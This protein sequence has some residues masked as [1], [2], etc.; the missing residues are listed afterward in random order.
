MADPLLA[1]LLV[2]VLQRGSGSS[3]QSQLTAGIRDAI[4]SGKLKAGA[5]LP[6]SRT[7]AEALGVARVTVVNAYDKLLIDGYLHTGSSSGTFVV[8]CLLGAAQQPTRSMNSRSLSVRGAELV[9]SPAGIQERGGAFVPGVCDSE[10]FP[11]QTWK[12]I[13]NRYLGEPLK[14]LTGYVNYGGYLPLRR[15]LSEYLRVSRAVQATPEQIIVTMGSNQSIDLCARVLADQGEL[16]YIENPSYWAIP[17]ILRACGLAVEAVD[18]DADGMRVHELVKPARLVVVTPSHQ[19]PMGVTMS[20]QRRQQLLAYAEASDAYVLEDDY[21]SEFRYDR[22]PLPSLQGTDP[23]GR[24]ILM[25]TFS[26]VMYPGMRLSY[27]VVPPDLADAFSAASLRLYRPGYLPLQAAIADFILDGH[28]AKHIL[29]MREVYAA[30]QGE[31]IGCLDR[32]FGSALE[33]ARTAAGVHQT[34][35]IAGLHD[36]Q[37]VAA[38]ALDHGIHLRRLDIFR[39]SEREFVDGFLLGFGAIALEDIAP[40]VETLARIVERHLSVTPT[41]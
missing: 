35:R 8:D 9:R 27:I 19:F 22:R 13:Q 17:V 41:S 10:H 1:D 3:L 38:D 39:Q 30:R 23:Y 16:A 31:L 24:V 2:S 33:T 18:V 6:S 21:D 5:R 11:F 28:F 26:K 25:G 20:E 34:I 4:R 37:A 12:R 7:L 32:H 29:K 14:M 15:A 40:A 36:I